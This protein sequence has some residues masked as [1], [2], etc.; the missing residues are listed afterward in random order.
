MNFVSS[1]LMWLAL[2]ALTSRTEVSRKVSDAPTFEVPD[3]YVAYGTTA[4]PSYGPASSQV[5]SSDGEVKEDLFWKTKDVVKS[6]PENIIYGP[7]HPEQEVYNNIN[8][9]EMERE[10]LYEI[11]VQEYRRR[12]KLEQLRMKNQK[13]AASE[14]VVVISD[15]KKDSSPFRS[16][17]T[18]TQVE[19]TQLKSNQN[20]LDKRLMKIESYKKYLAQH[21][22][23]SKDQLSQQNKQQEAYNRKDL[24]NHEAQPDV[25]VKKKGPIVTRRGGNVVRKIR[26]ILKKPS[27]VH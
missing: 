14:Q 23:Q 18:L 19:K 2:G 9:E 5:R 15:G 10:K 8:Q 16:H 7:V 20:E 21:Q 6:Q 24:N 25:L 17:P 12:K 4:L 1:S 26:K 27:S 11:Q 22:Q 3:N 13:E